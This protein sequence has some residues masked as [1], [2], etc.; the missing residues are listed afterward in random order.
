MSLKPG[1]AE[2]CFRSGF[3]FCQVVDLAVSVFWVFRY[4]YGLCRREPRRAK[5]GCGN[6]GISRGWR[7][8]QGAVERGG[9]RP[10]VF[11]AFHDPVISTA[12]SPSRHQ[13]NRG[14][15]GDSLLH[16]RNSFALAATILLAHSVSLIAAACRSN[17]AKP[18]LSFKCEAAFGR[19][20]S[21]SYGVA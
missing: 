19:D 1:W 16:W 5:R 6:V 14:G 15:T 18:M 13:S 2:G 3:P 8:F 11:H 10:P 21:F 7:D 4:V 12:V 9:N 17:C 20:F